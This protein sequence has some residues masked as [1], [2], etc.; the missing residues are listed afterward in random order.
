[1]NHTEGFAGQ[2]A[3]AL[4]DLDLQPFLLATASVGAAGSSSKK[5]VSSGGAKLRAACSNCRASHVACSHEIPCSRCV[6]Y[7]LA[8][9]CQYLPRKK[10]T[11]FKKRKIKEEDDND[12]EE[13]DEDEL[14][15]HEALRQMDELRR[16]PPADLFEGGQPD[17]GLWN[18][19]LTQLFG[20]EYAFPLVNTN[21]REPLEG[22][23]ELAESPEEQMAV[24]WLDKIIAAPSSFSSSSSSPVSPEERQLYLYSE[25]RPSPPQLETW[26]A[27]SPNTNQH[28]PA[29]T[30]SA[31]FHGFNQLAIKPSPSK[32]AEL[33]QEMK[34]MN[35][36]LQRLL[37]TA[38]EDIKALKQKERLR[39]QHIQSTQ[40]RRLVQLHNIG[41]ADELRKGVPALAM[42]GLRTT[43]RHGGILQANEAFRNLVGY[44]FEQLAAPSFTCCKL[45][46]EWLRKGKLNTEYQE[47]MAGTKSSGQDD[48]VLL[49]HD[50][51][52]VP[53]RA[54][55]HIIY[56][57]VGLPLYKM[58]YAFPL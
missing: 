27:S 8:D 53:V 43:N 36:R 20:N 30:G 52:E 45:F 33:L 14:V 1:M 39:E 48:L 58:F 41:P 37:H 26:L 40:S 16:N 56:D 9:S 35:E 18:A 4:L 34:A 5:K 42:F 54:F 6:K 23:I 21:V 13:E 49:R 15:D 2:P 22:D 44:S 10:R 12:D 55:F 24:S 57:D 19:T 38:L 32:E 17:T 7:G 11:N 46:P 50:G 31:D 47:I 51:S 25:N 3:Q 29:T 28:S